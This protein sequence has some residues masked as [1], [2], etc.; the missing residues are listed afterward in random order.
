MRIAEKY[1]SIAGRYLEINMGGESIDD[2]SNLYAD[3]LVSEGHTLEEIL[4]NATVSTYRPKGGEGPIYKI[5]DLCN[6]AMY[7]LCV[8][9]L[10]EEFEKAIKLDSGDFVDIDHEETDEED[11]ST[12]HKRWLE[13]NME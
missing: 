13:D 11:P 6:D 9:L 2:T 8:K 3:Y 5:S 1:K 12:L 4:D 7:E 10:T